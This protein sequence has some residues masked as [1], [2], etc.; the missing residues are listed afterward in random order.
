MSFSNGHDV[1]NLVTSVASAQGYWQMGIL[2]TPLIT[3]E[4]TRGQYSLMEQL[5]PE[6]AGPP[7]HVHD[8][9]DEVFYILDGE[10]ALQLG[11]Q[12]VTGVQGQL[13][14][15][16]AGTSHA[17]VVTS[18]T[19]RVL[20]FYVP[21]GLDMQVAMLGTPATAPTLPPD[22]AQRPPTEDQQRA[23]AERLHDLATQ[24]MAP[25][26]DLLAHLRANEAEGQR[27]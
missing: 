17:F 7:P 27:P 12:T 10:M 5:M 13:V 22:G 16:P 19:A 25:V 3:T 11:D 21:A 23:F 6:S 24:R 2:W 9:G 20:N 1:T 15:I 14:R 8:H 26:E 18:Q 4:Q